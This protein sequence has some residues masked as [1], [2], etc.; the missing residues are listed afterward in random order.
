[1]AQQFTDELDDVQPEA[2]KKPATAKVAAATPATEEVDDLAET[3]PATKPTTVKKA[4]AAPAAS[5]STAS[6]TLDVSFDDDKFAAKGDGL[7]RIRAE[8]NRAARFSILDVIQLKAGKSHF[9]DSKGTYRCLTP[10]DANAVNEYCCEKLAKEGALHVVGLAVE[11]TNADPSTGK[12]KPETPIEWEIGYVDMS[13]ANY[14]SIKKLP[15][16]EQ[17]VFDIDIIMTRNNRAFG[18]DFNKASK[19]RW[20]L[21]P[22][23]KE[24]VLA[25]AKR[26]T[27]DNG[28]KLVAKLGRH[29]TAM[30]WKTLLAGQA[31]GADAANLDEMD[32]L[33]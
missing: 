25:A 20:K 30:E 29:A 24:E 9:I 1:M 2:P 8:K 17:T 10:M 12:Y 3:K 14:H 13:A 4:G 23:L 15:E 19:A 21:N 18:Y 6:Q 28:A 22:E 33:T 26:F 27:R 5:A 16:E 7:K 31:A 32:D 11:Y